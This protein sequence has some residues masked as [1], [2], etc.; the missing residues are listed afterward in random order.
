MGCLHQLLPLFPARLRDPYTRDYKSWRGWMTPRTQCPSDTTVH[1]NSHRLAKNRACTSPSK[2]GCQVPEGNL[3]MGS[4]PSQE[5]NWNWDTFEKKTTVLS[6]GVSLNILSTLQV[7]PPMASSWWP[8]KNNSV[9]FL[10]TPCLISFWAF[11]FLSDFLVVYNGFRFYG[12][13]VCVCI[14]WGYLFIYLF[15]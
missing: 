4:Y 11:W 13:W 3:N 5:A 8:T 7:R 10:K 15:I 9:L 1:M 6:K 14:L 2:M 12:F